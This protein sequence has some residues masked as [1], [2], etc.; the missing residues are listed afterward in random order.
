MTNYLRLLPKSD[1]RRIDISSYCID[2]KIINV[3]KQT[4]LIDLSQ[5]SRNP[6][7]RH[8]ELEAHNT[9]SMRINFLNTSH[10][11]FW[12]PEISAENFTYK[13]SYHF[14]SVYYSL[15]NI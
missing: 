11:V 4:V 5:V 8:N 9:R 14:T 10:S 6:Y 2:C 13:V 7:L 3:A 15:R 1:I 12:Q